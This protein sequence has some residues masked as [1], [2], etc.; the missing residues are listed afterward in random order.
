MTFFDRLEGSRGPWVRIKSQFFDTTFTW[1]SDGEVEDTPWTTH[2][3]Y[4]K[5]KVSSS[6]A[7]FLLDLSA[8]N[9][10]LCQ[11]MKVKVKAK[12]KYMENVWDKI[13]NWRFQNETT[14]GF[15]CDVHHSCR[16]R[17]ALS[18][19]LRPFLNSFGRFREKLKIIMFPIENIWE[20]KGNVWDKYFQLN[21]SV[22]RHHNIY[23][24]CRAEL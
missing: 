20:C 15:K 19:Y 22:W 17:Q 6:R 9:V 7:T 1:I 4:I 10:P 21:F 14:I 13:F 2:N 8:Q 5:W 24:W 16:D 11:K 23:I 3:M 18:F 12:S